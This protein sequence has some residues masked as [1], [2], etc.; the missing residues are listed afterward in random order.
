[1]SRSSQGE[2]SGRIFEA[3]ATSCVK[4]CGKRQR[5]TFVW[6]KQREQVWEQGFGEM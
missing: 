6:L 2:I 5:G 3:D 4:V 1:M